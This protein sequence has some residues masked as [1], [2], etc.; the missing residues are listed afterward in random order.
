[1]GAVV[2]QQAVS[3]AVSGSPSWVELAGDL[4]RMLFALGFVCA[5]AWLVLRF[6]ASRG[7]GKNARGKRLEVIERLSIDPQRS[8]LIVRV[9]QRRLLIGVGSGAAPQL[10]TELDSAGAPFGS[11]SDVSTDELAAARDAVR[12]DATH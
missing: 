4:L 7:L 6:A 10:V 9:D 3:H 11:V 1:M 12:R 8:L 2:L 5:V